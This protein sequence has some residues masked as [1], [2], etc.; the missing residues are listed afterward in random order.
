MQCVGK[1]ERK[2]ERRNRKKKN[3]QTNEKQQTKKVRLQK[4]PL[5]SV[6]PH[7]ALTTCDAHH[8]RIHAHA[9][10]H[11][12][13]LKL[14]LFSMDADKRFPALDV[15][16]VMTMNT[17]FAAQALSNKVCRFGNTSVGK[18]GFFFLCQIL[19]R[20]MTNRAER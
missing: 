11:A 14:T 19:C 7:F 18:L 15:L 9:H 3:K 1:E 2:K 8:T 20:V 6:A 12:H 4:T 16:R 10:P 13:S 5:V 17:A